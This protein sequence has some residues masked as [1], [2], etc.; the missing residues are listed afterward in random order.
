MALGE[1]YQFEVYCQSV[2]VSVQGSLEARAREARYNVFE[3]YLI[4]GDL[5]LLAHHSDD[6]LETVLF[7]LFRGGRVLGLEGMPATRALGKASL[8]R[9]MLGI[10]RT[11]IEKYASERKLSWCEDPTNV[12]VDADR[13]YIRHNIMPVIHSRFPGAKK[14]LLAGLGR[15]LI[16]RGQLNERLSGQLKQV[17]HSLDGLKLD[18]LR[19][20]RQDELVLL[21]T[22]WLDDL[23]QLQPSG[24]ML[25]ELAG[26]ILNKN[27][28]YMAAGELEFRDLDN[29]IYV[30]RQLPPME[31]VSCSLGDFEFPGGCVSNNVVKGEGL[32]ASSG[33][34][35]V[36]RS[37]KEKIRM[38]KNRDIKKIFQESRVPSWIRD[39]VPLV[40]AGS[41]LVAIAAVPNW[42]V[43]MKVADGW[44]AGPE[45]S[46]F[47]VSLSLADRVLT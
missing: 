2:K 31:F 43:S 23:N 4:E 20:I 30:L 13:N 17:R 10:T 47:G 25:L 1:K 6:Q 24:R 36:F 11:D 29:V 35:M 15:D 5:L 7:K 46:G 45:E 39:R 18:L 9:P 26:N 41:E 32:R 3:S 44:L 37:G 14:A 27:R 28:I 34:K 22:Q 40:Y 12:E 38:G 21:L 8:H 16:A 42:K 33:Y 19:L